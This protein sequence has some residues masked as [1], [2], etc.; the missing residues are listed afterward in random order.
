MN[1]SKIRR[2][3]VLPFAQARAVLDAVYA[4]TGRASNVP[5]SEFR[6]LFK[7]GQYS[8]V[9]GEITTPGTHALLEHALSQYKDKHRPAFVDLGS[10]A[11]RACIQAALTHR[12]RLREI[13]GVELSPSRHKIAVDAREELNRRG[14]EVSV[15]FTLGDILE[16]KYL[17]SVPAIVYTASLTFSTSVLDAVEER[18]SSQ[19][20]A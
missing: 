9:Y 5:E 6:T 8:S 20:P 13:I 19:L 16:W 1:L 3:N 15:T 17:L 4:D 18:C 10:G 12:D 11:G 2:Q 14:H 7:D